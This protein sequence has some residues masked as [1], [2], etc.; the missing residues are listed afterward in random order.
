MIPATAPTPNNYHPRS[1]FCAAV[2]Q[3]SSK[4]RG[5]CTFDDNEILTRL[6]VVGV[7]SSTKVQTSPPISTRSL[8]LRETRE[9]HVESSSCHGTLALSQSASSVCSERWTSSCIGRLHEGRYHKPLLP[10]RAI[11]LDLLQRASLTFSFW[12]ANVYFGPHFSPAFPL[13]G[14]QLGAVPSKRSPGGPRRYRNLSGTLS[15]LYLQA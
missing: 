3:S 11:A 4:V 14:Q 1:L 10:H 8:H 2:E 15:P 7:V 5:N 13:Q 9:A 6:V 12:Y